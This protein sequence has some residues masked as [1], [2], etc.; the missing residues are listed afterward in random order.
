MVAQ[1]DDVPEEAEETIL[2]E[3]RPT[4][5]QPDADDEWLPEHEPQG[6]D[7]QEEARESDEEDIV[8]VIIKRRKTTSKLKFNETEQ[9][10]RTKASPRMLLSG[11]D[12]TVKILRD[13]IGHLNGVIQSS[14][15]RKSVLETRLPSLN[16]EDDPDVDTSV[17][18]SGAKPPHA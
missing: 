16:G 15:A 4:V 10:L 13:E 11:I 12:E 2:E 6:E 7:A 1:E 14:I 18:D 5:V 8:V 17:D 3:V 9:E